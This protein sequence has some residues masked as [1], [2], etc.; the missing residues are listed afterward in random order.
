MHMEEIQKNLKNAHVE[1]VFK[2][3][4]CTISGLENTLKCI[5]S[6]N[7]EFA[8]FKLL[9]NVLFEPVLFLLI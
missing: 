3:D 5:N 4:I 1:E 9:V 2:M 8:Q 7:H 6:I